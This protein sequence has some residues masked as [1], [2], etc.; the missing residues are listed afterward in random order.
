METKGE[1]F[2]AALR[3]AA[4]M[5]RQD[6]GLQVFDAGQLIPQLLRE[7]AGDAILADAHRLGDAF[8]G[9][10]LDEIV[11]RLAKQ[12][13]DGRIVI[14]CFE[15]AVDGG[16]VEIQLPGILRLELPVKITRC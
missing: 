15:Q 10:R 5:R 11:L 7:N 16:K 1:L 14:L 4:G 6:T 12:K 8:Q 9:I 2:V 3:R 13:P